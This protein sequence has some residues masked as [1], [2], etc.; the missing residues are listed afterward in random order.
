M[1]VGMMTVLEFAGFIEGNTSAYWLCQCAC[2]TKTYVRGACLS[3]ES[4]TKSCG[5]LAR[6]IN[7]ALNR[8]HGKTGTPE[9]RVWQS[10]KQ[11][12]CNENLATYPD[13]G[14]RGIFVC[15]QWMHS[16]QQFLSDMGERPNGKYTLERKDNNKGYSPENCIWATVPEQQ[17]NKRLTRWVIFDGEKTTCGVLATRFGL[18]YR[19]L[20]KR[21][22]KL[23]WTIERAVIE[24]YRR[25]SILN[26]DQVVEVRTRHAKGERDQI[27]LAKEYGVTQ[28]A[29]N[30]ILTR[31]NWK[32]V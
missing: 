13:Y 31:K 32:H 19:M 3:K 8:T 4:A 20:F 30:K 16:F 12:C 6:A 18:N 29:M 10:M 11:R 5:C 9:F 27:K 26:Q 14:G 23:G 15:P 1:T 2:G 25:S 22:F 24:P 21:V 7:S 28:S 17:N